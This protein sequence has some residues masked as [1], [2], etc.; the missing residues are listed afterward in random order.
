[1][2]HDIEVLPSPGVHNRGYHLL[3]IA[4]MSLNQLRHRVQGYRTP[5]P[6]APGDPLEALRYDRAVVDN[7]L[8][9]LTHYRGG[10]AR[11]GGSDVLELGPGL[12]LGTGLLL[13]ARGARSYCA[14]DAHPLIGANAAEK[15]RALANAVAEAEG[16]GDTALE[17]LRLLAERA[18]SPSGRLAYRH[19]PGFALGELDDDRA[20]LLLG[21][22]SFEHFAD[23]EAVIR[24]LSRVAR[25]GAALVTEIDLQTHTRW[26]RDHDPLSVYRYRKQLYRSLSFSGS[27][28]RVRP[29]EYLRLLEENDF[30][31]PRF[32]PRRVLDSDYV[33]RVEPSLARRF[34]GDVEQLGWMSVV[35]CATRRKRSRYG[36]SR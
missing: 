31:N 17:E 33:K 28:N 32:Y 2:P 3:G 11:L 8:R 20:D 27:P 9:H 26:L 15:H 6:Q 24:E 35:L 5:R 12:D 21:H 7:W 23:M 22:S 19:L 13:L 10:D 14:V 36:G 30:S 34:R 29:D 16:L 18:G 1:M 25:S 4:L